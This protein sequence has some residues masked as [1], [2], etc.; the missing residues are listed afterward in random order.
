MVGKTAAEVARI[1]K[2]LYATLQRGGAPSTPAPTPAPASVAPP[3]R[4]AIDRNL[5]Y[6]DPEAYTNA[7][8][9]EATRRA[10]A[11]LQAAAPTYVTP[12]AS[13][14]RMHAQSH[15]KDVWQHY[16]PEVETTMANVAAQNP[17]A[18]GD[19]STW[20]KVIDF[21]ASQHVDEIAERRAREIISRGSDPG[22]IAS[23]GAAPS[24]GA[25]SGSPIRKMFAENHPAIAPY[26]EVGL[27]AQDVID[28]GVKMGHQESKY[29]EMLSRKAAAVR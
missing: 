12:L 2:D 24:P 6:N 3:P 18:A 11:R 14:A 16:G 5:I 7:V 10:E 20:H 9:D 26:R 15:R 4:S 25:A 17:T 28:H 27:S 13:M 1:A 22:M 19:I 8:L 23:G 21:V 29:A